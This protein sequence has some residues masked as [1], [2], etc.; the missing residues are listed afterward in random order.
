MPDD[1]ETYREY[2]LPNKKYVKEEVSQSLDDGLVTVYSSVEGYENKSYDIDA[3]VVD[4][5]N[6]LT[7]NIRTYIH[8]LNSVKINIVIHPSFYKPNPRGGYNERNGRFD[9][10]T[11]DIGNG[12]AGL[13]EKLDEFINGYKHYIDTFQDGGSNFVYEGDYYVRLFMSSYVSV[14]GSTYCELPPNLVKKHAVINVKNND[15]MCFK[16]AVLSAIHVLKNNNNDVNRY[17]KWKDELNFDG[18]PFPVALTDIYKF[19]ILNKM[20]INVLDYDEETEKCRSLYTS[21]WKCECDGECTCPQIVLLLY[22]NHYMW[23]KNITRLLTTK[24]KEKIGYCFKCNMSFYNASSYERHIRIACKDKEDRSIRQFPKPGERVKFK[25]ISYD[26]PVPFTIYADFESILVKTNEQISDNSTITQRHEPCSFCYII[27]CHPSYADALSKN[28]HKYNYNKLV[29]KPREY[30]GKDAAKKFIEMLVEDK[31]TIHKILY[32]QIDLEMTDEDDE[33]YAN[34]SSCSIC[35]ED[36]E[37]V[38]EE[39]VD[40]LEPYEDDTYKNK[41]RDHCHL[42]GKFRGAAHSSC[43]IKYTVNKNIPVFFHNLTGYDGHFIV[44]ALDDYD[45]TYREAFKQNA[46]DINVIALS[47]EKYISIGYDKLVFKDS[48]KFKQAS[49]DTLV[50]CMKKEDLIHTRRYIECTDEQFDLITRKGVYPYEYMDNWDKFDETQLPS[51][52]DFYSSMKLETI[53][54]K[55]YNHA[56]NIWKEFNIK[57]MREYCMFYQRIDVLLLADMFE[58]NRKNSFKCYGLDPCYYFTNPGLAW[59]SMLRFTKCQPELIDNEG[60]Y[61]LLKSN[62][63]GGMTNTFTRYVKANN[64]YL[65][66]YDP[67]KESNYIMYLDANGLYG[68]AMQQ[69]LPYDK[70]DWDRVNWSVDEIMNLEDEGD[71]GYF[72]EVDLEYP[73]HLHDWHNDYPLAPILRDV[74]LGEISMYNK[75][76][77]GMNDMKFTKGSK[78]LQ[79]LEDRHN[80]L[81][82]FRLLKL[83]MRHG[84]KIKKIHRVIK[85]N[86]SAF[87]R[88]FIDKNHEM[89]QQAKKDKDDTL[90]AMY[91]E[92]TNASYGKTIED[93]MKRGNYM[94][95]NNKKSFEFQVRKP[96]F[97]GVKNRISESLVGIEVEKNKIVMDKPIQIG[98]A[99]LDLSKELMFSFYYD[100]IKPRYKD[101]VNVIYTDTDSLVLNIRCDDFYSDMKEDGFKDHFNKNILGR[102]KDETEGLA[103]SEF[104]ALKPKMYSLI[105]PSSKKDKDVNKKKAK[106]INATSLKKY[107]THEN[108]MNNLESGITQKENMTRFQTKNHDI[109]TVNMTKISLSCYNDKSYILD[110]GVEH[111]SY[112]HYKIPLHKQQVDNMLNEI[113]DGLVNCLNEWVIN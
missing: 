59:D 31:S 51:N 101:K 102:F 24:L 5:K 4:L 49:L 50:K 33:I 63:R 40:N 19:E 29:D 57:N 45:R 28:K 14:W 91:K 82:H 70:F 9:S 17:K 44:K 87:M 65:P 3:D 71:V 43:N 22:N 89:R 47:S 103:I 46:K 83:Y 39:E 96:Q 16:W 26:I 12:L 92:F 76:I 2:Q 72:F 56:Q 100:V 107:I 94:L 105:I 10:V 55:H 38:P 37:L 7:D 35:G 36:F 97:L 64:K 23:V 77:M 54:D 32:N 11:Y 15:N 60:I 108:Y 62:I 79:T 74:K 52:E 8:L 104:I 34:S 68:Y 58:E 99:V 41:V 48:F 85:F 42:T 73:E 53:K 66:D 90:S 98:A 75:K 84:L 69:Y 61:D 93:V 13:D 18:I 111:Y 81:V 95:I 113:T 20:H 110:N 30:F 78:L 25:N 112:G 21:F 1:I 67:N 86:Q 109:R 80:Y 106:G 27:V 6:I 88:P